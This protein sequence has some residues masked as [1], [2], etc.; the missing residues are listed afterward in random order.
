MLSDDRKY[1]KIDSVKFIETVPAA[2]RRQTFKEFSHSL[3]AQIGG[4]VEHNTLNSKRFSQIF[5]GLG[6]T[7]SSGSFRSTTIVE[8]LG[9]HECSIASIG[10]GSDNQ[11]EGV[12]KILPTIGN[13]G[14]DHTDIKVKSLLSPV[15]AELGRPLEIILG[16]HV[17]GD[18]GLNDISSVHIDDDHGFEGDAGSN[19]QVT[20][21]KLYDLFDLIVELLDVGLK[22]LVLLNCLF[23]TFCPV[24]LVDS[25]HNL[26]RPVTNPFGSLSSVVILE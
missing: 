18:Q 11:S 16:L 17:F 8:L 21:H 20:P 24:N 3:V 12:T 23:H 15:V 26:T 7:S 10:Q 25:E 5:D 9:S 1:F 13:C 19:C 22:T 14:S 6:L 2:R 4:A